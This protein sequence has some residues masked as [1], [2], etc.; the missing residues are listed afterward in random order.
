MRLKGDN[1][2]AVIFS[3]PSFCQPVPVADQFRQRRL[4][5]QATTTKGRFDYGYAFRQL[6]E[7]AWKCGDVS[8]KHQMTGKK[9]EGAKRVDKY[10][11]PS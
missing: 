2:Y 9:R 7:A 1:D 6:A 10:G 11:T 4:K 8:A 3:T 5:M